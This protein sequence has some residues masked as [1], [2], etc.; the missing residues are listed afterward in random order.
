METETETTV[1]TESR[2][3]ESDVQSMPDWYVNV[4]TETIVEKP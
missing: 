4:A 1:S 3:E 2:E